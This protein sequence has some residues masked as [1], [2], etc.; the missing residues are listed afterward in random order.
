MSCILKALW[1]SETC[2][3]GG[4]CENKRLLL[5]SEFY[6]DSNSIIFFFFFLTG[7]TSNPVFL[8]LQVGHQMIAVFSCCV[9][10]HFNKVTHCA[11]KYLQLF[12]IKCALDF[13]V[14]VYAVIC[15]NS[16]WNSAH[17]L[18]ATN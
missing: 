10:M 5:F 9:E 14:R 16:C 15:V 18:K 17:L 6:S 1:S 3:T 13:I 8:Y 7:K 4:M 2:H 11:N 12:K